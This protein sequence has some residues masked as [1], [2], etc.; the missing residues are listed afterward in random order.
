MNSFVE[1]LL[2]ISLAVLEEF[3]AR[4]QH[5]PRALSKSVIGESVFSK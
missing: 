2:P 1:A 5:S 4:A 3:A